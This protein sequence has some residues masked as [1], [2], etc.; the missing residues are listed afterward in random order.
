[1]MTDDEKQP[2][3]PQLLSLSRSAAITSFSLPNVECCFGFEEHPWV[4]LGDAI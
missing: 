3:E 2:T 4:Q 1:M